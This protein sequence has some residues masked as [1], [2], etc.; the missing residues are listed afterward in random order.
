MK[1][2]GMR[3]V[4]LASSLLLV[5]VALGVAERR[6]A[7]AQASAGVTT[8]SAVVGRMWQGRVAT[9]KADAYSAYLLEAGVQSTA[10]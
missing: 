2:E 7:A 10:R 5:T 9:S 4:V 3:V 1:G 6:W 8:V